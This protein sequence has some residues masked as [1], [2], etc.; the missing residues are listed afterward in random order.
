MKF[1][2]NKHGSNEQNEAIA[3]PLKQ[4]S[5]QFV[6]DRLKSGLSIDYVISISNFVIVTGWMIRCSG[7]YIYHQASE[8]ECLFSTTFERADVADGYNLPPKDA[9][10]FLILFRC[11][12]KDQLF[13]QVVCTNQLDGE[14][15]RLPLDVQD[16]SELAIALN[17]LNQ[18]ISHLGFL[19]PHLIGQK[20]WRNL[21]ANVVNN[22]PISS[23]HPSFAGFIESVRGIKDVGGLAIGWAICHPAC[24][25]WLIGDDGVAVTLSGSARW[26]RD[27]ITKMYFRD[28]G[29]LV[30]G[31]GFT[32]R[33]D[34]MGELSNIN[35]VGIDSG[36]VYV[37]SRAAWK[38]ASEDPIAFARWTFELR[39]DGRAL[40]DRLINHDGVILQRLLTRGQYNDIY[41][42]QKSFDMSFG[43][44][45][46]EPQVC[47]SIPLFGRVDFMVNQLMEFSSDEYIRE[48][49][50]IIYHIDDPG[51]ID[52]VISKSQ[53]LF[54]TYGIPFKISWNGYNMGFAA[55]T[56][57]AVRQGS[58]PLV[59]MLNSD[60]I[61]TQPGWLCS[62]AGWMLKNE[63]YGV[64]GA[65]LLYPNGGVQHNGMTCHWEPDWSAYLNKHP[66]QGF[67]P[68][69]S[70]VGDVKDVFLVTAACLLVNRSIFESVGALDENFLIGDFED[71]DFCLKVR[72]RGLKIGCYQ[73]NGLIHLERQSFMGIGQGYFR[74]CVARYNAIIHQSKWGHTI[75]NYLSTSNA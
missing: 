57:C 47:I 19:I 75:D 59:L 35:L 27:D 62:M 53:L 3:R 23:E 25:L 8:V 6:G 1:T 37:I 29:R 74:E 73:S 51:I 55:A 68:E 34:P 45:I 26:D 22:L 71:S 67:A 44:G 69:N 70:E 2:L 61:P 43:E 32:Q 60:V 21:I 7:P 14:V 18:H 58:A 30:H 36:H 46:S 28:Y 52:S 9:R 48:K 64:L 66:G 31:A 54:K 63:D 4:P 15:I 20:E 17:V 12:A 13:C 10:G 16:T 49:C 50:E 5:L 38:R 40:T 11:D 24:Q 65:R 72:S 41:L 39:T 56:N 33:I 42:K